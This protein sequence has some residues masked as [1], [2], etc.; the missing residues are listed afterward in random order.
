MVR[1]KFIETVIFDAYYPQR[2][3]N[4]FERWRAWK[5]EWC[6]QPN[7][8]L[9][10][11][12]ALAT[13]SNTLV[14]DVPTSALDLRNQFNCQSIPSELRQEEGQ[15]IVFTIHHPNHARAIADAAALMIP[16]ERHS[17]GLST[18]SS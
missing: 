15:V 16:D 3:R 13:A 4:E 5:L 9:L 12:S 1:L 7:L 6:H 11:A 18:V 2:M 10:L 14:R 8:K 17:W